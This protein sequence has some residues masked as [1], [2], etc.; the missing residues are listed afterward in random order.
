MNTMEV[1]AKL[2]DLC[3][4]GDFRGALEACY[5]ED[6]VSVEPLDMG[7]E[8]RETRGLEKVREKTA[9]WEATNIVHSCEV[10][11][12]YPHDDRFA[13]TFDIDV[14]PRAG[15]MAGNRFRMQEVG[16]YTVRDGKVAREE[17]F[18]SMG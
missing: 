17:F 2:V 1:G 9:Q 18:Y 10:D 12:P 7:G 16:V 3:R 8:G 5:A 4:Q 14:T 13:V 11:G 15:P 6:I